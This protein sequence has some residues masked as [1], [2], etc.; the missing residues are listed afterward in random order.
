[1]NWRLDD[2]ECA[3]PSQLFQGCEGRVISGRGEQTNLDRV[4]ENKGRLG[5]NFSANF[6]PL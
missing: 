6:V 2:L 4:M 1:M 5:F 3:P